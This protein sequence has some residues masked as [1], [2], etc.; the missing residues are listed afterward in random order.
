MGLSVQPL[1]LEELFMQRDPL[2]W[3]RVGTIVPRMDGYFERRP[4]RAVELV[5]ACC[6]LQWGC[7][8]QV[9]GTHYPFGQESEEYCAALLRASSHLHAEDHPLHRSFSPLILRH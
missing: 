3:L 8:M 7:S 1:T 5:P 2:A 6:I 4:Q 9:R